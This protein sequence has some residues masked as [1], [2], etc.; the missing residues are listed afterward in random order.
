MQM[1]RQ[2]FR[3]AKTRDTSN[4]SQDS[5]SSG[6]P[7]RF[8]TSRRDLRDLETSSVR[9]DDS[10]SSTLTMESRKSYRPPPPKRDVKMP[11]S[12]MDCW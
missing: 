1:D 11:K 4:R 2:R 3:A 12:G 5:S 6:H 8:L 9:S 7:P 10:V